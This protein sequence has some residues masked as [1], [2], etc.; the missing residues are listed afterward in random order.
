MYRGHIY[1]KEVS[2][3][4]LEEFILFTEKVLYGLIQVWIE[5][6]A[7]EVNAE[8]RREKKDK[9]Y[10]QSLM[11]THVTR[12]K[13][14]RGESSNIQMKILLKRVSVVC[15]ETGR[16]FTKVGMKKCSI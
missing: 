9:N 4:G 16:C 1:E 11:P 3:A 2:S 14:C 12:D 6:I 15:H 5:T 7:S 13:C 8:L 10:A